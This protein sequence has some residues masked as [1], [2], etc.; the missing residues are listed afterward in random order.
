[1]YTIHDSISK[2]VIDIIRKNK[3]NIGCST[4]TAKIE[5]IHK[6]T[7]KVIEDLFLKTRNKL[8]T[9]NYP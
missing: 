1:M 5:I 9:N 8:C 7:K 6:N 2:I 4:E 3:I